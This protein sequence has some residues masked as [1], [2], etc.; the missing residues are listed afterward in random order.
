[1]VCLHGRSAGVDLVD[2]SFLEYLQHNPQQ[3]K[4][5][6]DIRPLGHVLNQ[7][8]Q[9]G[10]DEKTEQTHRREDLSRECADMRARPAHNPIFEKLA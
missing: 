7:I 6:Q 9:D 10:V 2:V 5:I 3:I 4:A 8:A 1:M